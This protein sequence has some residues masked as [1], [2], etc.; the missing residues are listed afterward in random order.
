MPATLSGM[1]TSEAP[2]STTKNTFT[3]ELSVAIWACGTLLDTPSLS[4]LNALVASSDPRGGRMAG[5]TKILTVVVVALIAVAV[6]CFFGYQYYQKEQLIKA[7]TPAVKNTTLRVTNTL[8]MEGEPGITFK[9]AFER[10]EAHLKEI[11]Q[12]LF[13][14]QSMDRSANPAV[15]EAAENYMK[16]AQA[17]VR[18]QLQAARKSFDTRNKR[19]RL[20][21]AT[22]DMKD[23]TGYAIDGA[24]RFYGRAKDEAIKAL[25]DEIEIRKESIKYLQ[26]FTSVRNESA[27]FFSADVLVDPALIQA[28]IGTKDEAKAAGEAP[29][30]A[31][32]E[33][34]P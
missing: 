32:P 22:R 26:A 1:V 31:K 2:E 23:A 21:E 27:K 28:K 5:K 20:T 15:V 9:E 19:D 29:P 8:A 6:G 14:V 12:K 17:V 3:S 33:A 13:D 7:V 24:L 18:V 30:A 25:E 16:S 4:A 10:L 11:E 34:K